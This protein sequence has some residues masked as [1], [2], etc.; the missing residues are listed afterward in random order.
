[1]SI[2]TLTQGTLRTFADGATAAVVRVTDKHEQTVP[3]E[4]MA[5]FENEYPD[6]FRYGHLPADA[7]PQSAWW[8]RHF[9]K[10]TFSRLAGVVR[11]GQPGFYLFVRGRPE[12]Y[13]APP[14]DRTS[15]LEA[16]VGLGMAFTGKYDVFEAARQQVR[17][18]REYEAVSQAF[19]E[20][21]NRNPDVE[22]TLA[23]AAVAGRARV[24]A[25][26]AEARRR[27][28]DMAREW[29]RKQQAPNPKCARSGVN[30]S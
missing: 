14:V 11:D 25:R 17:A 4:L 21:L 10:S 1:M 18:R 28:E 9:R 13:A 16:Y 7:A 6:V 27:V 12:A 15:E 2:E 24:E 23:N 30:A 20:H 5:Y 26:R 8:E 3:S 29:Q 19:Q 22:K